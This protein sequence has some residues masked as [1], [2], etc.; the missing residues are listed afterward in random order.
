MG[1][2]ITAGFAMLG[3]IGEDLLE[4][5]QYVFAN[6]G[7]PGAFTL[8][9]IL[10]QYNP[11]IQGRATTWTWPLT[12]GWALNAAVSH[13][14]VQDT[15]S[16]VQY[17]VTQLKTT[18]AQTVNFEEDW[19]ILTIFIGANN[20]CGACTNSSDSQPEYFE[21]NLL[22]TLKLIQQNIPRVFVNLVTLFNISGVYYAGEDYLYCETVW[23]LFTHECGCLESGN[24][25]DL[26]WMDLRTMQFN[27][28][29]EKLAA[30]FAGLNNPNFT[31][32]VQPGLSGIPIAKYGEAY[33][34]A[35]D[36]FHP[37]LCGDQAFTY[38]LWNNL[39]QP[40]GKKSTA[41]NIQDLHI[42]C[43]TEDDYIQ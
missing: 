4:W 21:A 15:P 43:P 42:Y 5:R 16:Q 12:P 8:G 7:E 26:D 18:Y 19:K 33:L 25:T 14:S 37:S 39:F 32:V 36:C 29:Q 38:A 22:A 13:A 27:A 17:L 1:D 20:E 2:S 40:V 41:P 3:Y 30:Q 31:V 28:I 23:H 35:L 6:G 11:N 10:A 24:K 34:S 9:N